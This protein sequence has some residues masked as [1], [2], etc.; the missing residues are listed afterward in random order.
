MNTESSHPNLPK[1][2]AIAFV[3][4]GIGALP[5]GAIECGLYRVGMCDP[6]PLLA[7]IWLGLFSLVGTGFGIYSLY[8]AEAHGGRIAIPALAAL[9]NLSGLLFPLWLLTR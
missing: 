2:T 3:L 7:L 9:L 4:L 5:I 1:P 8:R 6:A